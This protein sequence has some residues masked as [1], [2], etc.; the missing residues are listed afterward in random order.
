MMKCGIASLS[1][2]PK[3]IMIDY[4]TS[5]FIIDGFVKSLKTSFSVIP[6]Q[7][8]IHY[9]QIFLDACLRRHDGVSDFLRASHYSLFDIRYSLFQ[10]FF[11][12]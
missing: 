7:A 2:F 6:A 1:L 10:C 4:L 9:S 8:G 11:F 3:I 12:D 5:T